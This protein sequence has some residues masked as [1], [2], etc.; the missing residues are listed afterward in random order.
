MEPHHFGDHGGAH[1]GAH[2]GGR[3]NEGLYLHEYIIPE[4]GHRDF[5]YNRRAAT[6]H[7]VQRE[8]HPN[9]RDRL[10]NRPL[11]DPGSFRAITGNDRHHIYGAVY[12]PRGNAVGFERAYLEPLD[13]GGRHTVRQQRDNEVFLS[14]SYP[15]R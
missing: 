8:V 12:H 6:L 5:E 9:D 7:Q 10:V 3:G 2:G 11:N 13:R 15:P 4:R 14:R 1:G